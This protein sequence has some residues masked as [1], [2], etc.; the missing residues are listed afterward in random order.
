MLIREARPEEYKI[1]ADFQVK[2]A[3][4]TEG[5][6]LDEPTVWL[7]V[8][9]VFNDMSKGKYY[10]VESG[11]EVVASLLTTFEWSDWRN[12]T[13]LWLQS[14]YVI[15]AFRK[16]GVFKA[17]YLHLKKIVETDDNYAGIRLYVDKTNT[18]AQKVYKAVGMNGEHYQ[19]FEWMDG[20]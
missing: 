4:E 19:L 8:Q 14:V 10:V 17:M 18:R 5:I 2:M 11:G 20:F 13:T 12:K 15:P 1:I 3:D 9:A 6:Q 16:K 7:G